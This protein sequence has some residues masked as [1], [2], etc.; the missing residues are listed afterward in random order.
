[1]VIG[2]RVIGAFNTNPKGGVVFVRGYR[3]SNG[4]V[5]DVFMNVGV[6]YVGIKRKALA[7]ASLI[8]VDDMVV[9]CE[10]LWDLDDA[11]ARDLAGKAI[12]GVLD[13]LVKPG[14]PS[15]YIQVAPGL[16]L[17][18]AKG[19]LYI[20]GLLQYWRTTEPGEYKATKSRPLTHAKRW[21][22]KGLPTSKYKTLRLGGADFSQVSVGGVKLTPA[23]LYPTSNLRSQA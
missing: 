16:Y 13:G 1:M 14:R 22:T 11:T 9:D 18:P 8:E 2:S 20:R 17:H 10:F 6:N 21:I 12:G 19:C 4:S 23:D 5:A 7:I 3:G 15:P